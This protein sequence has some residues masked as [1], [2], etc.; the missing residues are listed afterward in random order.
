[1]TAG[2]GQHQAWVHPDIDAASHRRL[3]PELFGEADLVYRERARDGSAATDL[4]FVR[5]LDDGRIY[6][7]AIRRHDERR[8]RLT[9][10]HRINLRDA[11]AAA[12][13]GDL[14]RDRRGWREA[15]AE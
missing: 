13:R 5:E 4:V 6:R 9:T 2:S 3:L 7:A 15:A 12:K 11:R 1:M 10:L 8:V 14:L